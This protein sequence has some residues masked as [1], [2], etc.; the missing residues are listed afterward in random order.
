M[1]VG[2]VNAQHL[3]VKN[4]YQ[5]YIFWLYHCVIVWQWL[6][7]Y[8]DCVL[9]VWLPCPSPRVWMGDEQAS[10]WAWVRRGEQQGVQTVSLA[11]VFLLLRWHREIQAVRQQAVY[12]N[13]A[14]IQLPGLFSHQP[15]LIAM[16]AIQL[17]GRITKSAMKANCNSSKITIFFLTHPV[18]FILMSMPSH[19]WIFEPH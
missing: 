19:S 8:E 5:M 6:S 15:I 3:I 17:N 11:S 2:I 9:S 12:E 4:V 10:V 16:Y 14:V 13:T 7:S 1:G 18:F